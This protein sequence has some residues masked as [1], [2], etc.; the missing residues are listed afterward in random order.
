MLKHLHFVSAERYDFLHS[1][2]EG[3]F[4]NLYISFRDTLLGEPEWAE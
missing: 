4:Q 2:Y 3:H 1:K